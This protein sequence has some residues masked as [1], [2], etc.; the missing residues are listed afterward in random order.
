VTIESIDMKR[1]KFFGPNVDLP[2]IGALQVFHSKW[3]Y[4]VKH[5]SRK[6]AI[7]T[8]QQI[9]DWKNICEYIYSLTWFE[10]KLE[11]IWMEV[12]LKLKRDSTFEDFRALWSPLTNQDNAIKK[13]NLEFRNVMTCIGFFSQKYSNDVYKNNSDFF[14]EHAWRLLSTLPFY[15]F[16]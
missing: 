15:P 10:W 11:P 5:R 13:L 1:L 9:F 16:R 2:K 12:W 3:K 4:Q 7:V 14:V 6:V 8:S